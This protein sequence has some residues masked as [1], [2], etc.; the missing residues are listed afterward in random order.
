MTPA[1]ELLLHA[2]ANFDEEQ[3]VWYVHD[4]SGK[5]HNKTMA[6]SYGTHRGSEELWDELKAQGLIEREGRSQAERRKENAEHLATPVMYYFR[7]T[8]EGRVWLLLQMLRKNAKRRPDLYVEIA[9]G[10]IVDG[11][12]LEQHFS[13]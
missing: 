1:E 3:G 5:Q 7:L 2:C 10:A 6:S 8:A 12:R 13:R 11:D 9:E 4:A